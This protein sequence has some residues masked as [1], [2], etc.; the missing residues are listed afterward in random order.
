MVITALDS[1]P[2]T[3]LNANCGE[4]R[5]SPHKTRV[6][7]FFDLDETIVRGNTGTLYLRQL[8]KD[9]LLS[10]FRLV[11]LA[12]VL[13][14]YKF[15][16]VDM[17]R[18]LM[19]AAAMLGGVPESHLSE[20][21]TTLYHESIRPLISRAAVEAIVAH[22]RLGH[23][24]VLLT[25]QSSYIAEPVCRELGIAHWLSTRLET[26]DGVLTGQLDGPACYG[27]GKCQWASAFA[28][29]HAIDLGASYF[30]T[31]SYSDVPMLEMVGKKRVVNPD[32]RLSVEA[33]RRGWTVLRFES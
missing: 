9:G 5:E 2:E 14:R 13:F 7:A 12:W 26:K 29:E 20:R 1:T 21:C 17:E 30:Y 15:S 28:E 23:Q 31:D 11:Q 4:P 18:L 27:P 8:H 33:I 32:P 22:Q 3:M 6:A 25:A 24:V 19:R 10:S 16:L